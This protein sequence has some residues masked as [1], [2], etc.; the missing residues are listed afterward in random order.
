[1]RDS[2]GAGAAGG[3]GY[4]ALA[5]MGAVMRPGVD[6]VAE[7]ANLDATMADADL[8]ITGEG[9]MDGQTLHGKTPWGVM[10]IAHKHQ[11]PVVALAGSLGE[12]YQA[13]YDAGLTAAFS[14]TNGPIEL[15]TALERAAVLLTERS[16]DIM[17]LWLASANAPLTHRSFE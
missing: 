16:T 11:I 15:E 5:W 10:Q 9:R 13:L 4:A 6:V 8:V 7:L 3:L 14:L 17:R 12:G 2:P 1:M